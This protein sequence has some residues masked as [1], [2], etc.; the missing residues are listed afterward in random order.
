MAAT[1]KILRDCPKSTVV[2]KLSLDGPEPIHDALRGVPGA[3]AACLRTASALAGL[4]EQFP[5]FELG[6]NSVFC[7]ATQESMIATIDL[8]AALPQIRTHT[9][10]LARG[11]LADRDQL[12]ADLDKYRQACQYLAA[13]LR[14]GQ[15]ATYRFGGARL[16]AAQDILQRRYILQTA[17]EQRP[18]LPCLAG[19]LNLVIADEG[20]VYPCENFNPAMVMGNI[21]DFAGELPD[22]LN[23]EQ[24][25]R[26]VTA[27]T[28]KSCFCTHE[29]Y[30]MTNILFNP[31]T[32][33]ALLKEYLR[34]G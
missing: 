32:Y 13:K 17:Q 15:A 19:R 34:L 24:A 33:P 21:R 23:S 10:S 29:C 26:V 11:D 6:I 18:Q 14:K 25:R 9:I 7:P 22:L 20:T 3:Y 30:M 28:E 8:V 27:I 4:Q 31:A 2:V 16:K 1:A 5:N 12:T